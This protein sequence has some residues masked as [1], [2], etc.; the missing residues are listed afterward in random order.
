[1]TYPRQFV[2]CVSLAVIA[3]LVAPQAWATPVARNKQ[4]HEL[5][6]RVF[7][8][9]M[10]SVDY[11][12]WRDEFIP[13][14][15]LLEEL[16][17]RYLEFTSVDKELRDPHAVS[18]GPD[19]VPAWHRDDE[20]DGLPFRMAIVTDERV[21]DRN[22]QYVF[23]TN[24][25]AAEPCG[26]EGD[27]RFLED[28]LIWR[29]EDPRHKLDDAT[30]VTGKTH[31]ITV[32]ELLERTKIYVVD[33]V[34]DAWSQ[35]D[36]AN[37]G[38]LEWSNYSNGFNTNRLAF[39][40][41][42]N[43]P[44]HETL[45]R[46][47]YTTLTQ[48]ESAIVKYFERVR[49]EELNGRPFAA[50]AD[51]H[52][53]L[54]AGA[55]LLH[56]QN[57]S[58]ERLVRIHDFAERIEQKMEEALGRYITPQ[59]AAAYEQVMDAAGDARD[60]ALRAY[61]QHVGPVSEKAAYLT[62]EWAEY[63]TIWDHLDYTV[64]GTWGGWA[65]ADAGL[66]A[67]TISYEVDCQSFAPYD[68][69]TQQVFVDNIQAIVETTVVHAA[70][71]R[72]NTFA[73]RDLK[74]RVGFYEHGR[75]VTHRDG[76]PVPPPRQSRNPVY[77]L[78]RQ[79]PYDVANTDYFRDL[80]EVVASPVA[81]VTAGELAASLDDLDSFVVSDATVA[82]RDELGEF[83]RRG[84]NLVLTD[85]ALRMLPDLVD[86]PAKAIQKGYAYVGYS[87]LD[88]SHRWTRGLYDRA[89]QMYDPVGLGRPLLMERDQYWPCDFR[90]DCEKSPTKNSS[91][92]WSVR[93]A[94]WEDVGG[95]TIG[96]VDPTPD[97]H[98]GAEGTAKD[99]TSIGFVK[100]GKGRIV[101]FGALLPQ[102]SEDFEHWFGL[103]PYTITIAGQELLL[104]ALTT[105]SG[106]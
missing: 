43:F 29:T 38:H 39:H 27:I 66:G 88:R 103:N 31:E 32:K 20:K 25:H 58:A 87:D 104:H 18:V 89:R 19:S 17:P 24:A 14:M 97:R 102:P 50:A 3:I 71:M 101:I 34:P 55:V 82:A 70:V 45:F 90:G 83:V 68:G 63:A 6:G 76:N 99:K 86:V 49:R 91:A 42:W 47:G 79:H 95:V 81:E 65:A 48:P 84:G 41:G 36:R 2:I 96:T 69:R 78:V 15:K 75:R 74:G 11:I 9:P 94:D 100:Q 106:K 13:G 57:N 64:T 8:E 33:T 53:P 61:T 52:G 23:L 51:M 54:P 80:R 77:G 4:E 1:M 7:L 98:G 12:Q 26:R 21:P 22:K 105:G 37:G 85:S 62:L 59:G 73:E 93:R 92:I 40:D 60:E 44:D 10:R 28:L 16:Y 5:Y 72:E 30:G 35:G 67:D 56:E 46:N